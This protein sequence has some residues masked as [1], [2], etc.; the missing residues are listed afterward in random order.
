MDKI[1][2]T[3]INKPEILEALVDLKTQ[4]PVEEHNFVKVVD[5]I[6]GEIKYTVGDYKNVEK[7]ILPVDIFNTIRKPVHTDRV[8]SEIYNLNKYPE[9]L[10]KY[11]SVYPRD[12]V[13]SNLVKVVDPITGEIKTVGDYKDVDTIIRKPIHTVNDIELIKNAIL[14]KI[15]LNK[16][17]YGDRKIGQ[18]IPEI[19]NVN[20]Y[21]KVSRDLV[22]T[23][24][25]RNT[26]VSRETV[27]PRELLNHYNTLIQ[28][29]ESVLPREF[30][31]H[32]N[33][34]VGKYELPRD[35]LVN[36]LD[37]EKLNILK[38]LVV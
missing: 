31:N 1:I 27:L 22:D 25:P 35:L 32:Y 3:L 37:T 33:T 14:K 26:V 20:Q 8:I 7:T 12:F 15:F 11:E 36:K 4:T 13:S 2:K 28:K 6:T 18:T 10:N 16:V 17:I 34:I 24:L 23:V 38:P 21:E 19:L 30:L 29:Y 5:P 9:I